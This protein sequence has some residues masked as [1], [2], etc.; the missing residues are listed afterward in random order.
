MPVSSSEESCGNIRLRPSINA[1]PA[2]KHEVF[3]IDDP[4][5]LVCKLYEHTPPNEGH[6][7]GVWTVAMPIKSL[8]PKPL[9]C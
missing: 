4:Y 9:L 2:E 7:L 6:R 8:W 5:G 3:A 1:A